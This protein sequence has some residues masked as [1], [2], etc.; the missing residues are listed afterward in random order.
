MRYIQLNACIV[1]EANKVALVS[2]VTLL[3]PKGFKQPSC[4]RPQEGHCEKR[5][6]TQGGSQEMA[7][8]KKV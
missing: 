4:K 6:E 7:N 1:I 5:C 2:N 8:G 3:T